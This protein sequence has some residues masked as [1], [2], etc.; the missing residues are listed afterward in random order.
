[1]SR[2]SGVPV[3][4]FVGRSGAGKTTLL[5]AVVRILAAQGIRVAAIKH[6]HKGFEIDYPGKDSMRLRE[7]GAN[8][9]LLLS[10]MRRAWVEEVA[11]AAEPDLWEAVASLGRSPIDLLLVEGFRAEGMPKIELYVPSLGQRLCERD[12]DVLAVAS[13]GALSPPDGPVSFDRNDAEGVALLILQASGLAVRSKHGGSGAFPPATG[14]LPLKEARRILWEAMAPER[15]E[16]AEEVSLL[17]SVGRIL[18][19]DLASPVDLPSA[20]TAAM[21][22]YAV[23]AACLGEQGRE[24]SLAGT[25]AAGSPFFGSLP[26]GSCVR[27]FTGALL[28]EGTDLVIPQEEALLRDGKVFLPGARRAGENVRL[29]AESLAQGQGLLSAGT[30][31]GPR[32]LALL[33][34]IG[35]EKVPVRPRLRVGLVCT[36]KE[37]RPL[38]E[39]IGPGEVYDS[40]RVFLSA[41]LADL[42]VDLTDAGIVDDD[43]ELLEEQLD[44]LAEKVDLLVTTGGVSVGEGDYVGKLLAERNAIVFRQIAVKPGRPFLFARWRGRPLFGL[45]GTPAAVF[46]LFYDLVGPLLRR[47]MGESPPREGMR[48]PV[49]S[50]IPKRAGRTEY[51]ACRLVVGPRGEPAFHPVSRTD[52]AGLLPAASAD[53]LAL[54]PEESECVEVGERVEV[55]FL[56]R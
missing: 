7:A 43:P 24:F 11:S 52:G 54:L 2:R 5:C 32:T 17:P 42:G 47:R 39:P 35:R 34:A 51:R 36:G 37:L 56:P 33:S 23:R 25:A 1:M 10:P 30:R 26:E 20:P 53:L 48:L 31:I 46:V 13:E 8:P 9:V 6:A 50:R 18:A 15:V 55:I 29:K 45:P 38:G 40:N 21:D 19:T 49:L 3:V 22:G 4:A 27:I 41:A 28:P 12:P 16:A 14:P 44:R